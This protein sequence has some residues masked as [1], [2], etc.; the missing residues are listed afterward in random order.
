RTGCALATGAGNRQGRKTMTDFAFELQG[1]SKTWPY[2][3]LRKVDMRLEYGQILGFI[4]PN[5]AGKSTT[6]RMLMGLVT[7]EGGSISV[8][9]LP[10]PQQQVA[11]KYNI[12]FV[13]A[14]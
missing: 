3:S 4:G 1:I 7:P 2:F 14:D 6:I 12:G 8:F 9:G 13:S 11:I 5:G 10:M